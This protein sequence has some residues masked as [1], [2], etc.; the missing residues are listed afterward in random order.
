MTELID[1]MAVL[2]LV[3]RSADPTDGR[4]QRL[5]LTS[6]G[7][8]A[9]GL[10]LASLAELNILMTYGF[11]TDDIAVVARWLETVRLRF[12]HPVERTQ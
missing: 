11:N 4:V 5:A 12:S 9:R 8:E 1:R 7:Q 2:D 3:K 6:A 10:A